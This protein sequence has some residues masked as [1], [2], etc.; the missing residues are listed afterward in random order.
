[1]RAR[2]G[3]GSPRW[4]ATLKRRPPLRLGPAA[5]HALLTREALKRACCSTRQAVRSQLLGRQC[6]AASRPR[7]PAALPAGKRRLPG[8]RPLRASLPE[9]HGYHNAETGVSSARVAAGGARK[10]RRRQGPVGS[11]VYPP[12][13]AWRREADRGLKG[14][15]SPSGRARGRGVRPPLPVSGWRAV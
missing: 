9:D 3:Q 12:T 5:P 6:P 7:G 13:A 11:V 4:A 1:M 8:A 2:P 15:Q 14:L 10:V